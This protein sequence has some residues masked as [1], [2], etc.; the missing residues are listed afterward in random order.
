MRKFSK[1]TP[2]QIVVKLERIA[3]LRDGGATIGQACR[4]IGISE[5]TYHR[6]VRDYGNMSRSEARELKELREKNAQLLRLLG[7]AEVEKAAM[8]ELIEGKF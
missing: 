3:K 5:A 8:R 6:W 4:E 1:N 7:Q 2:E